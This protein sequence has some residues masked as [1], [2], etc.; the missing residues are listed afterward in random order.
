MKKINELFVQYNV[1]KTNGDSLKWSECTAR[2]YMHRLKLEY[3]GYSQNYC[4]GHDREDVL[5]A[6]AQYIH[7]WYE[8]EPHMHLW[9]RHVDTTRDDSSSLSWRHVDEFKLKGPAALDRQSLGEF[10]GECKVG[11][12]FE[13]EPAER[14]LLAFANDECIFRTKRSNPKGWKVQSQN[15]LRPKD[16]LGTGRMLSGWA[17]E[18]GGFYTLTDEELCQCNE[19][20]ARRGDPPIKHNMFTLKAFDYD[21]NREV[22]II[23]DRLLCCPCWSGC[24]R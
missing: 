24:R 12:E 4:D 10:G 14:P 19:I 3:G 6:R 11:E 18:F 22:C 2:R 5:E 7:D 9:I 13:P 16:T 1:H 15:K 21:N 17:H 23:Y 8:L 20:R